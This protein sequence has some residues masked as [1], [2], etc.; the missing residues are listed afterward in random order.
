[1][2][3]EVSWRF[4]SVVSTGRLRGSSDGTTAT[5]LRP[6]LCVR[7]ESS[8]VR[9]DGSMSLVTLQ[10]S[11]FL[12]TDSIVCHSAP[13][14]SHLNHSTSTALIWRL[15]RGKHRA[16]KGDGLKYMNNTST[17]NFFIL[18][19]IVAIEMCIKYGNTKPLLNQFVSRRENNPFEHFTCHLQSP[20]FGLIS[21]CH[22]KKNTQMNQGEK[23]I[24]QKN[25]TQ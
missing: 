4:V 18:I 17:K 16:E 14:Q 12:I 24:V 6:C 13:G 2:K 1:M 3:L 23:F 8:A 21:M 9:P 7:R 15:F 5:S 22:K 20:L 11:P 10:S 25:S 19:F